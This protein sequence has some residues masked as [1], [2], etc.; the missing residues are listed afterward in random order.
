MPGRRHRGRRGWRIALAVVT[1][2]A[3]LQALLFLLPAGEDPHEA[4]AVVV[5]GGP[6]PRIEKGEQ[7]VGDGFVDIVVLATDT[8]G[9]CEPDVPAEQLCFSPEPDT[10]RGEA[11]MVAGLAKDNGWDDLLLVVQNE[12]AFRAQL[13]LRRC[14]G[15]DVRITPI[16]VRGSRWESL[17]RTV[18][19]SLA[20]PKALLFQRS[21]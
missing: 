6:G 15:A 13:R 18:Y 12:Q 5:L 21:C 1:L 20:L 9:N 14:L 17:Y 3:G 8:P 11:R 10:T 4:D 16:T 2:V 19:E 7:L